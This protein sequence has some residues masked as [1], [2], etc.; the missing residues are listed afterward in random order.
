VL[1]HVRNGSV[2]S[3]ALANTHPFVFGR[4]LFA[5]NGT[6]T[7]FER[8][9]PALAEETHP[10]FR[11]ARHGST[12]SEAVFYWLLSRMTEAGLETGRPCADLLSL[13]AFVGRAVVE[14]AG[15]CEGAGAEEPAS[16]NLLLT[17][18][19]VL[20]A[21]RWGRS[22]YWQAD[23][24]GRHNAVIASEPTDASDWHE[25]PDHSVLSVDGDGRVNCSSLES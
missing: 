21:S 20:V 9:G 5:H 23:R 14:L 18:G 16:L 24:F 11:S 12:D 19:A 1:A 3:R 13:T 8:V 7:A 4:W 22:L 25:V 15:R 10:R 17:D 6:V 2:G